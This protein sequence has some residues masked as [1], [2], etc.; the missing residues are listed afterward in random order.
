MR[1]RILSILPT[2]LILIALAAAVWAG[3]SDSPQEKPCRTE[4]SL[5]AQCHQ[6][7]NSIAVSDGRGFI[8]DSACRKCHKRMNVH[9]KTGMT[10][11]FAIPD[12]LKLT[13]RKQL[14]CASCHDLNIERFSTTPRKA[15]SLFG[16]MFKGKKKYKSYYLAMDNRSGQLCKKCHN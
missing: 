9:H 11:D 16:R 8:C 6:G 5:C 2:L 13:K 12:E 15:Q 7:D 1:K 4:L 10:V 14:A 3:N